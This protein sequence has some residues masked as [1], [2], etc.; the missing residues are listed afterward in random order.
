MASASNNA[1]TE[2]NDAVWATITAQSRYGNYTQISAKWFKISDTLE[3]HDKYGRKS[4]IA[5]QTG[6]KL[7]ELAKDMEYALINNAAAT[8]TDPRSTKGLKGW[9]S[10]CINFTTGTSSTTLTEARFN[11]ELQRAWSRGGNPDMVITPAKSKRTISTFDALDRLTVN[12]PADTKKVI[13][14]VDYYQSDFGLVKVYLN[15]HIATDDAANY[16]SIF[17]L[18]KNKWALGTL[19]PVTTEKLA[20]T[21]LA[22]G[23][24]IS[25]EY[26]LISRAETASGRIKNIDNT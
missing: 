3:T 25:T 9:I 23:I 2:G 24:Q 13:N 8:S 7:K 1:V 12:V 19:K 14:A 16:E 20:K 10:T 26:G 4:E 5:Y 22:Q 17:I 21:G 6:L 11:D 18:E 15:R